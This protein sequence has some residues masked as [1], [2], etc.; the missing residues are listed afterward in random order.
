MNGIAFFGNINKIKKH[1]K[2]ILDFLRDLL[3]DKACIHLAYMTGI[4]P[5]KKYGT[6]SALNMFDEFSMI[7][8]G[9]LACYVGFTEQEVKK[10]CEQYGM[11][12]EEVK[13]WYDGYSFDGVLSVYSPRS[14]VN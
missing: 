7:D 4:L 9:P 5:I 1:R 6:H 12:M 2:N 13:N 14:V 11:D 10:L 3:K 8:P